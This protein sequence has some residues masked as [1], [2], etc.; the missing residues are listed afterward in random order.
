MAKDRTTW[1]KTLHEG[2]DGSEKRRTDF[3]GLKRAVRKGQDH[4][5]IDTLNTIKCDICG[6]VLVKKP[7]YISHMEMH[8]RRG[9]TN[10]PI[11][12]L[13]LSFITS[14]FVTA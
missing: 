14:C 9:H 7:G 3:A 4:P 2:V 6:R 13:Q 12:N 10:R 8:K 1:R 11:N 5:L